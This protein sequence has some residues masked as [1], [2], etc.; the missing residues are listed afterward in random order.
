MI[1]QPESQPQEL[2]SGEPRGSI[3]II[4]DDADQ[5]Y[6]LSRRLEQLGFL[7]RMEGSGRRGLLQAEAAPP[8]L[9]LLDLRLPDMMGFEVCEELVDRPLTCGIPVI[10]ISAME[11]ADIIR[12]CRAAGCRYFVRKPYDP[13]ALL[14]LI[15][16]SLG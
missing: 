14:A 4:D 7:T 16:T 15:E 5:A 2:V 8:D 3:L 6:V 11:G 13:N 1:A 10:I 12:T 9:V